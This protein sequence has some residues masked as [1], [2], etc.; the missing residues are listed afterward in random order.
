MCVTFRRRKMNNFAE[1]NNAIEI[2][3]RFLSNEA[4]NDEIVFLEKWRKENP[5]NESIFQEYNKLWNKTE[6]ASDIVNID[7]DQEWKKFDTEIEKLSGKEISSSNSKSFFRIAASIIVIASLTFF[8]LYFTK[9]SGSQKYLAENEMQII[10]LPDG[11]IVTLNY[12]S[13]L[14]Y[15]KTFGEQNREVTLEGEAY[16]EVAKDPT[17][18]FIINTENS[19]IEVIGTSFNVNAYKSNAD[20]EVVVNTGIVALSSKKIP[21]E[22][23]ILKQGEKG[24]LVKQTQKLNLQK[25]EDV[26]FLSWKTKKL[27]FENTPLNNVIKSLEKVYHKDFSIQS[28]KIKDCLLTT[29]FDNQNLESIM[30]IIESTLDVTFNEEKETITITGPGC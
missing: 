13:K 7:V 9:Y 29:T 28:E 18:P 15:A 19:V 16:F 11:T 8:G 25:N 2:I 3:T 6:L 21:D 26:N 24:E 1:H 5:E 22:K 4:D 23:I 20:V 30:L 12:L 10:E 27:I 17:K 14:K